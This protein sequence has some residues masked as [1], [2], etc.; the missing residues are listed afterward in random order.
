M[1]T[2]WATCIVLLIA[3]AGP[4]TPLSSAIALALRTLRGLVQAALA[5]RWRYRRRDRVRAYR[6]SGPISVLHDA[7][8]HQRVCLTPAGARAPPAATMP[9]QLLQNS[10]ELTPET[11]T[12]LIIA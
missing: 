1:H 3:S 7:D 12:G 6:E 11:V 9:R 5:S 10:A 2:C 8:L 4:Q